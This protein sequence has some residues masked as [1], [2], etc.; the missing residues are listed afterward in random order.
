MAWV[1]LDDR[2]PTHPK[3]GQLTDREF[4]I[5]VRVLCYCSAWGTE[6]LVPPAAFSEIPHLTKKVGDRFVELA[7]WD[8]D[9]D[10]RFH[11]HDFK[12]YGPKDPT[13]ADRQRRFRARNAE[14][15]GEVTPENN[16]HR[17]GLSVTPVSVPDP[18]TSSAVVDGATEQHQDLEQAH[19]LRV[20]S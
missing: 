2:F 4:R 17:N 18:V 15:N 20:A 8:L 16:G 11:V 9:E 7:L 5:H 6:G 19:Y 3:V 14:R 10:G 12:E 1:R 13:G